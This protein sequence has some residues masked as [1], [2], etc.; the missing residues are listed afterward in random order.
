MSMQG[1]SVLG[2]NF[3][4]INIYQNQAVIHITKEV[5]EEIIEVLLA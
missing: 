4:K 2:K 3:N 5:I 1:M